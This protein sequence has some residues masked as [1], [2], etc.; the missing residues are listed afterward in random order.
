MTTTEQNKSKW[1]KQ[2]TEKVLHALNRADEIGGE[3]RDFLTD[4]VATDPRYVQ[5]RKRVA[6]LF[7]GT[8]ESKT[9][10]AANATAAEAKRK[11]AAAPSPLTKKEAAAVA[12]TKGFGNPDIKAQVFGK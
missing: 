3:I 10:V 6:K 9:E 2:A 8:Y 11:A 5:A 4:R 1:T 12:A 7:G